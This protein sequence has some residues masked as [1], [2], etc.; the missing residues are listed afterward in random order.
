MSETNTPK[1]ERGFSEKLLKL[2]EAL[3][4]VEKGGYNAHHKYKFLRESDIKR[5]FNA[6]CR[7]LG[8]IIFQCQVAPVGECTG[9]NAV[10]TVT[11][12]LAN[13]DKP[14]EQVILQGIGGGFDSMDKAPMKAMTA[15][16]KYA[17]ACGLSVETGD[18]PEADA[19]TDEAALDEVRKL[20]A[21]ADS[22][23]VLEMVKPRI[24]ALKGCE[25]FDE[26]KESFKARAAALDTK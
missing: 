18:D 11:L 14:S 21:A 26:L 23:G 12:V 7:E 4:Y 6:S 13:A 24:A 22:R 25:G 9:K 10:V 3:A 17:V 8:I 20:I 5:K 15:A 19:S 1:P 2:Y 16:W